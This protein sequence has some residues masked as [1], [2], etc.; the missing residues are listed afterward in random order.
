MNMGFRTKQGEMVAGYVLSP[1]PLQPQL[2]D[3]LSWLVLVAQPN[4]GMRV[5]LCGFAVSTGL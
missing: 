5:R 1:P 3:E 2:L 4:L